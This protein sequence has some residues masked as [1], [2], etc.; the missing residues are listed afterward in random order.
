MLNWL[1]LV[2]PLLS[3]LFIM[4]EHK[5]LVSHCAGESALKEAGSLCTLLCEN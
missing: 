2:A 3:L 4:A 1:Q 5:L